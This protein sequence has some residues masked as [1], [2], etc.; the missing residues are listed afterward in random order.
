MAHNSKVDISA[1]DGIQAQL[2]MED[3]INGDRDCWWQASNKKEKVD[4]NDKC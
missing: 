1:C 4:Y 3:T 2:Q